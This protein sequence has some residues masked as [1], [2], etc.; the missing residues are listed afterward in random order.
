MRLASLPMYDL[1][2]VRADWAAL[3]GRARPFLLRAGIPAPVQLSR[4]SDVLPH[5]SDPRLVLSQTCAPPWRDGLRR[6]MAVVGAFDFGLPGCP[7]GWYRSHLVVRHS[8]VRSP[9]LLLEQGRVAIN[10]TDSHSG[11]GSLVALGHPPRQPLVTGAHVNSVRALKAGLADIAAIDAVTWR[12][13]KRVPGRLSGLR[14]VGHTAPHPGTPVILSRRFDPDAA[15]GALSDGL[16]RLPQP[17]R[18]RLGMRALVPLR[19]ADYL[20]AA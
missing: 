2:G 3:W 7:P 9:R 1:P 16:A 5:W 18:A 10:G 13:L 14:I 17:A 20:R 15:W 8:E 11:Y 6:H 19:D 4:P 12:Y